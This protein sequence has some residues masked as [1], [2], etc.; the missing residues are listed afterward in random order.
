[1]NE[2]NVMNKTVEP[3]QEVA[4]EAENGAYRGCLLSKIC[5][6]SLLN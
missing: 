1:V 6:R 2:T 3:R 5:P 4:P